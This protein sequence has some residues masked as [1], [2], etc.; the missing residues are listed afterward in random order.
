MMKKLIQGGFL[1]FAI[2]SS[3][4]LITSCDSS[5]K[6]ETSA[7]T[8]TEQPTESVSSQSSESASTS[9]QSQKS[10]ADLKSGNV[11]YIAR[12]VADVQL[13]AGDYIAQLQQSKQDLEQAISDKDQQQLQRTVTGLKTQL[14]G[15][16][17]TL[18]Q[19]NLKSREIND[20]RNN[21]MHANTQAL[22]SPL[23]NGDVDLS[24]VD[25]KKVEQ[26]LGAVQ[27]EMLKLAALL[28]PQNTQSSNAE[29]AE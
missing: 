13:K 9:D 22:N 5:F 23:M 21:I 8:K 6:T 17:Q 20:I 16:N 19:L 4:L 10:N 2:F 28:I 11:F 27:G 24:Q 18:D 7:E 14:T 12:D 3:V 15:F 25:F 29:S 1:P 26:Q